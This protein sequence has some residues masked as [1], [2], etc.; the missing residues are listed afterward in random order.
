MTIVVKEPFA[1][2][3]DIR[4]VGSIPRLGRSPGGEHGNPLQYSCL[5]NPMDRGAWQ[6]IVHR[7]TKCKTRLKQ[8]SMHMS[9]QTV[10]S[11]WETWVWSLDWEDPLEKVRATHSGILAWRIIHG[12]RSLV[13]YSPW[14]CKESDKTERLHFHLQL[15]IA[16][17]KARVLRPNS[18]R[19]SL[20]NCLDKTLTDLS[21]GLNCFKPEKHPEWIVRLWGNC[22]KTSW[23][24]QSSLYDSN[25]TPRI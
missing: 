24:T 4:D 16:D 17:T 18:E 6:A 12:Q 13:G 15:A 3:R 1:N 11:V 10:L 22:L 9:R 19:P 7:V 14:G 8:L 2:T 5:E 21:S 25:V 23:G 20:N